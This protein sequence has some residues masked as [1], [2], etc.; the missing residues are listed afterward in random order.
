MSDA[1][2][3][4][5][6][7]DPRPV[8]RGRMRA[9]DDRLNAMYR[10]EGWALITDKALPGVRPSDVESQARDVARYAYAEQVKDIAA[11]NE[12]GQQLV[13]QDAEISR[14]NVELG[15]LRKELENAKSTD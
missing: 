4:D 5:K 3:E 13:E 8:L 7:G 1:A 9:A 10:E 6:V 2:E 14:L 11:F 12:R 15:K